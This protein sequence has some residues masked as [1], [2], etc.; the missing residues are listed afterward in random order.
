MEITQIPQLYKIFQSHPLVCTDTRAIQQ[1]SLFFA[2]KGERFDAND[3]VVEALRQGAAYAVADR[4]GLEAEVAN[5]G[6]EK[7]RLVL[8]P[9]VLESLQQ[10][11][12]YHRSHLRTPEGNP[13]PVVALTGT[14]GKTTTKELIAAVLATTFRVTAT[15]GN[16]NNHIGVPLSLLQMNAQTQ[17]G[18]FEMGASHPGEIE[19][20]TA[21]VQPSAGLITNIGKAHLE[22]FGSLEGVIRCKGALMEYL[23]AHGGTAFYNADDP[24]VSGLKPLQNTAATHKHPYGA[25]YQQAILG[26]KD[27]ALTVQLP[28]YP[29]ITTHL[30]GRYNA[31]NILA[32]LAVGAYFGVDPIRAAQAIAA[33]I[34][35]NNR[36]QWIQTPSNDLVVDAY[37]ANP[38]SMEASLDN[39]FQLNPDS[40][41]FTAKC[42]IL[43]DMRELGAASEAEHQKM[44]SKVRALKP[45]A[46]YFV[47][48][49]FRQA[50][51]DS[52]GAQ[53]SQATPTAQD[54]ERCFENVTDLC[55]YLQAHPITHT[56][57][58]IKGSNSLNLTKLLREKVL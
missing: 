23:L 28:G 40:L 15:Q 16:L 47:G 41:R 19:Q 55:A 34:P 49:C 33:Y 51:Q 57:C 52:Q 1:G 32:A 20:L 58:L 29:L 21:L 17:I 2:L 6:L 54:G 22:G 5:A 7:D 35:S 25:N 31:P 48:P 45:H 14:N 9:N 8:V 24:V 10:L 43:G 12:A 26:E 56:T 53:D 37:N 4:V 44:L 50:V 46:V 30:I 18:L 13:V 36:S 27:A 3:F 42:V 39:F 38:T 11:A